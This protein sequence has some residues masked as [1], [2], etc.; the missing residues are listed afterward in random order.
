[1]R[2]AAGVDDL[3]ESVASGRRVVPASVAATTLEWYAVFLYG[4]ASAF[5]FGR[6][7]F[8][9]ATPLRG[10]LLALSTWVI[11]F[12]AR[13]VG[14]VLFGHVGDRLGRRP[15]LSLS[16]LVSGIAT[17][18]IGCLPTSA[19]VGV[20]APVLLVALRLAQGVGLGGGWGGATLLAVEHASPARRGR[21]GSWPQVGTYAGL[22]L[23]TLAFVAV[24]AA[25]SNAQFV[26]WGWRL[27]F[28][29]GVLL[30][31]LAVYV[32]RRLPESPLFSRLQE[33][34]FGVRAP[35]TRVLRTRP[36]QVALVTGMRVGESG[37]LYLLTVFVLTSGAQR[38]DMPRTTMLP[39]V[40]VATLL[41][42]VTTPFFGRLS[43][44]VGRRPLYLAGSAGLV[45]L[46]PLFF[47]LLD[48]GSGPVV[49]LAVILGV[50]LAHDL[51]YGPQAA[52]FCE[53]FETRVR[54]SG[55]SVGSQVGAALGGGLAPLVAIWSLATAGA[56]GVVV[57][58]AVFGLVSFL[59]AWFTGETAEA[60]IH[61]DRR[62]E[63]GELA[64]DERGH[65]VAER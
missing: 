60:D 40:L 8:P 14:A 11:G 44:R 39:G 62:S 24:Q 64:D 20:A 37:A 57:C 29:G 56:A 54:Y 47:A 38:L 49:W 17:V 28:L 55:V 22:L 25:T 16:L 6:H 31:V 18:L 10:T 59:S 23:S 36:R 63:E 13:P 58:L 3:P 52:W 35:V 15:A 61:M 34:E 5:V 42:L 33:R 51:M 48:D 53:L 1:M 41:G 2:S 12:L 65:P 45:V 46:S 9:A 21:N 27:P 43:D 30:L 4:T 7:F 19:Q 26:R 50:N 32:R